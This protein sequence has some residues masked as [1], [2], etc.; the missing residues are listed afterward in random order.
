MADSVFPRNDIVRSIRRFGQANW[1]QRSGHHIP[2]RIEARMPC[3]KSFGKR[4]ASQ[5]HDI[6][7]AEV[8]IR[9]ALMDRCAACRTAEI[10]RLTCVDRDKS[11][12]TST[13]LEMTL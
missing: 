8:H 7:T 13:R 1:K 6:Q 2:S 10:E 5:D 11:Q 9:I 4:I 12:A 3:L